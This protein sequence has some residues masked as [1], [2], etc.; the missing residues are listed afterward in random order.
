MKKKRLN[1][2]GFSFIEAIFASAIFIFILTVFVALYANFSKFYDRQQTEIKI[3]TSAR[4]A[5]KE[6]QS[7]ALQADQILSSHTFSGTTYSTDQHTLVLE[8]PSIDGA[9]NIIS[10]KY[11]FVVFYKSGKNLYKLVQ[12]DVSSKRTSGLNQISDAVTALTFTYN[13]PN[14]ILA[15]K[16]DSDIQMETTSGGQVISYHLHQEIYLRNI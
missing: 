9:G 12:A 2:S 10:G 13:N 6:L 11:D 7:W 3:G 1:K 16:I 8:L 14:L 15:N 5:V 4:E